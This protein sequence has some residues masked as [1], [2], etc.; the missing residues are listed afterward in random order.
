MKVNWKAIIVEVLKLA[1]TIL[2][3][4]GGAY[5]AMHM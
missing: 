3:A 5:T 2:G 1:V 4:G